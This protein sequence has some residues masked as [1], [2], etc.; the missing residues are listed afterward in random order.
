MCTGLRCIGR[1][2][3]KRYQGTGRGACAVASLLVA[4]SSSN[5]NHT[6]SRSAATGGVDSARQWRPHSRQRRRPPV[7]DQEE[8]R[9]YLGSLGQ[10]IKRHWQE[11]RPRM[12]RK[13]EQNGQ[14][15][16]ALVQ[17]QNQTSDA[18]HSLLRQGVP[19]DQAWESVREEWA[20]LPGE[21]DECRVENAPAV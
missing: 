1:L 13:L 17:A 16:Q 3:R 14:L 4:R 19:Y 2:R 20:F 18:L 6:R 9:N 7:E 21:D 15:H 10:Q 12:Y 5:W 8:P 11:H